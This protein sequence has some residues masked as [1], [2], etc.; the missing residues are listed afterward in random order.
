MTTARRPSG[1][2]THEKPAPSCP[3]RIQWL[4]DY[5]FK[6][7][8]TA[9]GTTSFWP[10]PR[11]PPG[12]SSFNEMTFYI[13]PETY[14]LLQTPAGLFS[15]GRPQR[16]SAERFLVPVAAR[17]PGLVLS[18]R[19][20][21]TVCPGKSCRATCWPAAVSTSRHPSAL[22]KKS[23]KLLT[24]PCWEKTVPGARMK[25]FHD[26]GYGNS[27]ATSG[28]LIPDHPMALEKGLAGH[29]RRPE[30]PLR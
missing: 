27:G 12:T 5:Y 21:S 15:P 29:P 2:R 30:G 20:W 4:R 28:H 11:A 17:A 7:G 13:V 23:K 10:G 22:L 19:S 6:G 25:W 1:S 14:A 16:R 24:R 8:P 9:A 18:R 26:H 3:P